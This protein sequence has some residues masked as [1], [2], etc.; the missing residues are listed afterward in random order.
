MI[1][2][3]HFADK[4]EELLN[5]E[6]ETAIS[7]GGKTSEILDNGKVTY[8]FRVYADGGEYKDFDYI[9]GQGAISREQTNKIV[10]YINCEFDTTGSRS[11]GVLSVEMSFNTRFQVM[12]PLINTG[13]GAKKLELVNTIR[14]V[15]D[16]AFR[17]NTTNTIV[18]GATTYTYGVL[19]QFAD[20]GDRVKRAEIGD[21]IILTA[22]LSYFLVQDG[23][24]S[25]SFELY[26]DQY[27]E[28]HRVKF[29]RLGFNRGSTNESVVPSDST[30]GAGKNVTTSTVFGFNFDM[31]LRNGYVD[32]AI[33]SYLYDGVKT[34]RTVY[35]KTPYKEDA[36]QYSM[37]FSDVSIN[38][39]T[40]KFASVAVSMVEA[41]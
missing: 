10:R 38:A 29:T 37:I 21:S 40:T 11:D 28:A 26:F 2:I 6:I 7:A 27:D 30:N 32:R 31:P 18:D 5:A 4:I 15:I 41:L 3:S 17:L 23:V 14:Q 8:E 39:E 34:P 25:A 9:D 13:R 12:I 36:T 35:L 16:N 20:T 19:Y 33:A 24:N 22:F 1:D